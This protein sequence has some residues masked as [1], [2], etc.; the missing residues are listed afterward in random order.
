MLFGYAGL[1]K[2]ISLLTVLGGFAG[3]GK[4]A[5]LS[6]LC[7]YVGSGKLTLLSI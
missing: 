1:D 5:L 6:V 7:G 2:L 4:F 3:L